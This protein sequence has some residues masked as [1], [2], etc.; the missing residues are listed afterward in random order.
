MSATKNQITITY[1]NGETTTFESVRAYTHVVGLEYADGSFG[2]YSKH[3]SDAAAGRGLKTLR[4]E[5][6]KGGWTGEPVETA[7]AFVLATTVVAEDKPNGLDAFRA[8]RATETEADDDWNVD[9]FGTEIEAPEAKPEPTGLAAFRAQHA[10]APEVPEVETPEPAPEPE[11]VPEAK[12]EP[13]E[14]PAPKPA[15]AKRRSTPKGVST[16]IAICPRCGTKAKGETQIDLDFG[17]RKMRN[18]KDPDAFVIRCQSH[19]RACRREEARLAR[20]EKKKATAEK[21]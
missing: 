3:T 8:E 5:I 15:K 21:V 2:H 16:D 13:V 7:R 9:A 1:P 20:A 11:P 19:C 18:A 14:A 10:E 6:R 4:N 12:P 17:F